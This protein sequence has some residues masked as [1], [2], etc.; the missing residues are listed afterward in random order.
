MMRFS[1]RFGDWS[2]GRLRSGVIDYDETDRVKPEA[3][4]IAEGVEELVRQQLE[5]GANREI[6]IEPGGMAGASYGGS[7]VV[8][9][10]ASAYERCTYEARTLQ[11]IRERHP[12]A[13]P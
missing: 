2:W 7:V 5:N 4:H 10:G 1:V 8:A 12:M 6:R 9:D 13:T 3:A 11:D